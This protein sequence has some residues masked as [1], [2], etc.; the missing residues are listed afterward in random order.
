MNHDKHLVS[1]APKG[2]FWSKLDDR[3]LTRK[4]NLLKKLCDE[5]DPWSPLP[6]EQIAALEKFQI[7]STED[8]F[9]LTNQLL[10]LLED[11]LEEK[12]RRE[13]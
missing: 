1:Q 5:V 13:K 8:P 4:I 2:T 6:P 3:W 10:L 11:A 7:V 9:Q 12:L